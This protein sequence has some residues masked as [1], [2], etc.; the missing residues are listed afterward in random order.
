MQ[1]F[2]VQLAAVSDSHDASED[3]GHVKEREGGE[4]RPQNASQMSSCLKA[5]PISKL[6]C[7][8][9]RRLRA[10]SGVFRGSHMKVSGVASKV[11]SDS[12]VVK[13]G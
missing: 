7:Y 10:Q 13:T 3:S 11:H 6:L 12:V 4:P 2:V 5:I 9:P 8:Q 1:E